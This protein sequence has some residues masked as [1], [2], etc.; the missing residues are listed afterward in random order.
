MKGIKSC[1]E[2]TKQD[3]WYL[4]KHKILPIWWRNHKN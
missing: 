3:Y 4:W 1:A 2:Q